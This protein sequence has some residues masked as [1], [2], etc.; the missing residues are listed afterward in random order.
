MITIKNPVLTG[1]HPDPS[2]IRVGEDYYIAVSTFEWFPG[3]EIYHS[4]NLRDWELAVRPLNRLS[5]LNMT[6]EASSKGVWA[7]CLSYHNGKFYLIYSDMKSTGVFY[8]VN[9]YLVTAEDTVFLQ[10]LK[11]RVT[12]TIQRMSKDRVHSFHPVHFVV[13]SSVPAPSSG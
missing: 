1:F 5:Q 7:P 10:F 9:N 4:K 11:S 12:F 8:D 13:L 6:G 2:M 3:V